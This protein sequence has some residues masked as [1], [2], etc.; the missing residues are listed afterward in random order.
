MKN[1]F[2]AFIFILTMPFSYSQN[3]EKLYFDANWK[4]T[5]QENASFYR[6][7]PS[8]K[9]GN[10]IL[11]EDFYINNI[12]Q[13]QGYVLQ[14]S[15]DDYVGDVVWFD[16]NG[17][18]SSSYQ[19]YNFS[20]VSTLIYYYPN[21]K[22]F[23][24]IQYKNGRKEGET[25][26][27]H[28]DGTIL[29]KGKYKAGK[30]VSGDFDEVLDGTDYRLN[31]SD[32]E[33]QREEPIRTTDEVIVSNEIG[34][35]PKRQI[36]KK[37]T[38]WINSKQPAQEI[39]YDLANY[40]ESFKQIDYDK[41]GTILQTI[42]EKDLQPYGNTLLNGVLF[43]YYIQNKF[44]VAVKSKTI[45]KN[46]RK[47]GE[48]IYY[49]PNGKISKTTQYFEGDLEGEEIEYNED[50]S[51]KASRTFGNERPL[52]GNFDEDFSGSLYVNLNYNNGLKEGEAIAKT[53]GKDSIVAKGIYKDDKPYNGTF[54]V[55]KGID[56]HELI[57][58]VNFKKNELQTV[59]SYNIDNVLRTYMCVN[60]VLEGKTIFYEAGKVKG[61]LEY[62]KGLPYEGT[63]VET[64]KS[65]IYKKGNVTKEI[66]YQY[67][68]QTTY[69]NNILKSVY[70]ENGK[71]TK[72]ENRS[73][74]IPMVKKDSYVGIYKDD[75]PYSGYFETDFNEFNHVDYY[76]KGEIKFQYS[77]DFLENEGNF[78]PPTKYDIKSTYKEGKIVDGVEYIKSDK[79][80]VSK[81]WKNGVLTS[82]DIDLFGMHYFRRFHFELKNKTIEITIFHNQKKASIVIEKQD[83]KNSSKLIIE[84]KVVL[85]K[86][87]FEIEN[88]IPNMIGTIL[89]YQSNNE[90]K[91]KTIS[92]EKQ[93]ENDF[94]EQENSQEFRI[95]INLF[96]SSIDD[97][98]TIEGNFK[99]IADD[100]SKDKRLETLLRREEEKETL[101]SLWFKNKKPDTGI[102]ILKT[103]NNAYDLK[104]YFEGKVLNARK[105][106][107]FKGI[108]NEIEILKAALEKKMNENFK[109]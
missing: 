35:E 12:P 95:V 94:N 85:S 90:V 71:R 57:Q 16:E 79:Q 31:K 7:M 91:A 11:I 101:A 87:S 75:K 48:E 3:I 82:Y 17:F 64:G 106:V 43:N 73:F 92:R 89:Y 74:L 37:K 67:R 56:Q 46:G 9:L 100:F 55:E 65:T 76:E 33:A 60:D 15:E 41:S 49:Y 22:K 1:Q 98:E 44:A 13:S 52:Q 18:D 97:N 99:R 26:V 27:Y 47:H 108:N 86:S 78:M 8:K 40:M 14:D 69:Q 88:T 30:P 68:Y 51:V 109:Y 4:A 42:T 19:Y 20:D 32:N 23:K 34:D 54:I 96:L 105:N 102:L 24:S 80:L 53:S 5:T 58:V 103:A 61:K 50:G 45:F 107:D 66:Y 39:W 6:K 25:I 70:F 63:L 93:E 10:L 59:F 38:F 21:G 72:M 62:R 29:M 84:N 36:I 81:H 83:G 104:S 28:E 2:A 77:N